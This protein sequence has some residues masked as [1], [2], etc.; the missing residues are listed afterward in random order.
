MRKM[1]SHDAQRSK[2][3]SESNISSI[4]VVD[5]NPSSGIAI[6]CSL[7]TWSS[8]SLAERIAS[9]AESTIWHALE[10]KKMFL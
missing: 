3:S 8:L 5:S 6:S 9:C 10:T 2:G 7:V 4:Y 1:L